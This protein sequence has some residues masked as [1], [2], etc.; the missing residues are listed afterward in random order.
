MYIVV[1]LKYL[2]K[3]YTIKLIFV[4]NSLTDIESR[5]IPKTLLM[6]AIPFFPK[7]LS[8]LVEDLSII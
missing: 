2:I 5:I 8:M 1:S 6:I 4:E 3:N 7:S